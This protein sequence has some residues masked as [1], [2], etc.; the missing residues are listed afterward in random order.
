MDD[1]SNTTERALYAQALGD[2][3]RQIRDHAEITAAEA[4]LT[5]PIAA[6][7]LLAY[8][9]GELQPSLISLSIMCERYVISLYGTLARTYETFLAA[10]GKLVPS[11]FQ[12]TGERLE[13]AALFAFLGQ[14]A[15]V[16][17]FARWCC[18]TALGCRCAKHCGCRCAGC[19]LTPYEQK[20]LL[21]NFGLSRS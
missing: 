19:H 12:Q 5:T 17:P 6:E 3:L 13:L 20:L 4:V 10:Q 18:H 15:A 8:E 16:L 14:P 2:T 11:C 21:E 7:E 1:D 9:A